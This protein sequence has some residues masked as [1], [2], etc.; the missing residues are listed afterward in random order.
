MLESL[1]RTRRD[2]P[3]PGWA[4]AG[5][6]RPAR[7]IVTSGLALAIVVGLSPVAGLV[8][9]VAAET[10]SPSPSVAPAGQPTDAPPTLP[11]ANPAGPPI[12]SPDQQITSMSA[13][14]LRLVGP[15]GLDEQIPTSR[16]RAWLIRPDAGGAQPGEAPLGTPGGDPPPSSEPGTAPSTAPIADPTAVDVDL[17]AVAAW[18][19]RFAARYAVA[20][21]SAGFKMNAQ[22][23][24]TA[25]IP[26]KDGRGL[27]LDASALA[28]A[29][30][31]RR[32]AAGDLSNDLATVLVGPA[33]PPLTTEQ[34]AEL[35]PRLRRISR[36]TT[37][38]QVGE[39]NGFGANII[40]PARKIHGTLI[41]PGEVF[42]FWKV[43]GSPTLADGYRMG[44]AII[45]GRSQ[46]TGA[47]AG[48][49]CST[50]TTIF[51]AALRAGLE[52]LTRA[53]HYYYI[54][55]YPLGLDATVWKD[56][57]STQTVRWRNDTPNPIF[58]RAIAR[59]GIVT[60]ELYSLPTGRTVAFSTPIVHNRTGAA[61]LLV[62]TGSL[63]A[64]VQLRTEFPH[65]GMSVTVE[66]TVRDSDGQ[67]VHHETYRSLYHRVDGIVLVGRDGAA[68]A[69]P[70]PEPASPSP[71]SSS[72]GPGLD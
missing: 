28:V 62:Y 63:K 42:D 9:M 7:A 5:R 8:P 1:R 53:P 21:Q 33:A 20:G 19:E 68:A 15:D 65:S 18:L 47:F 13:A 46:P 45:N 54:D 6:S 36:W 70:A 44:G 48:G 37:H 3:T 49:I 25:V 51:N 71:P 50:S 11:T 10:G 12:G 31:L 41:L 16:I 23:V 55:R 66:R 60:F 40:I 26:S 35:M 67:L 72:P 58:I 56:G 64:G 69:G 52:M 29:E 38:W 57:R 14:P 39:N 24:F 32:R 17:T 34:A 27:D 61:D 4:A 2:R 30:A 59:P 22:G 43:V